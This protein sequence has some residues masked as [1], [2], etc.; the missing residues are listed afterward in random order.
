MSPDGSHPR[1]GSRAL[2]SAPQ[3]ERAEDV[4]DN[5]SL[6]EQ[7]SPGWLQEAHE[8]CGQVV[9]GEPAGHFG[10]RQGLVGQVVFQARSQGSGEHLMVLAAGVD[11]AGRVQEFFS[12][13]GL[14]VVPTFEGAPHKGNV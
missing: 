8:I 5:A 1:T 11:G 7:E 3:F 4:V 13:N 2:T 6:G 14:Q 9:A 10:A 12:R